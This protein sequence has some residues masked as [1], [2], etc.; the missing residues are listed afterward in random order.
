MTGKKDRVKLTVIIPRESYE[1]MKQ[2]AEFADISIN[3]F[4]NRAGTVVTQE[5]VST[6]TWVQ[7]QG[8][9]PPVK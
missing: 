6:P 9:V 4:L 7:E 5:Q 1:N 8:G 3:K 2:K